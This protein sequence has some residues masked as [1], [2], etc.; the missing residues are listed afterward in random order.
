VLS[1]TAAI[2]ILTI[3]KCHP[4]QGKQRMNTWPGTSVAVHCDGDRTL[5]HQSTVLHKVEHSGSGRTQ[6]IVVVVRVLTVSKVLVAY[7]QTLG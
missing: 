5:D 4:D 3:L 7:S 2:V 6:S 1:R